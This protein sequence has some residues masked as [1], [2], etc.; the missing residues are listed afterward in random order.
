MSNKTERMLAATNIS[1]LASFDALYTPMVW[2]VYRDERGWE[3]KRLVE[4]KA[5]PDGLVDYV[6][7]VVSQLDYFMTPRKIAKLAKAAAL[8]WLS[9]HPEHLGSNSYR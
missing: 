7:K 6:Y 3:K 4:G 9:L 1:L 2:E 8:H 5:L